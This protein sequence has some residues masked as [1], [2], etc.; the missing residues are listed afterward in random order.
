MGIKKRLYFIWEWSGR[1][2]DWWGRVRII[3]SF[4]MFFGGILLVL[5]VFLVNSFGVVGSALLLIGTLAIVGGAIGIWRE[6]RRAPSSS[7][8]EAGDEIPTQKTPAAVGIQETE[9]EDFEWSNM[10]A[11]DDV[12]PYLADSLRLSL[13]GMGDRWRWGALC[14][15]RTPD[16]SEYQSPKVLP[17]DEGKAEVFYPKDFPTGAPP[18]GDGV[19]TV[20]WRS[21]AEHDPVTITSRPFSARLIVLSAYWEGRKP[22]QKLVLEAAVASELVRGGHGRYLS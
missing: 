3:S 5:W 13:A 11:A 17:N 8:L 1:I 10:Y 21:A 14:S 16:G 12:Q 20:T 2:N 9:S 7:Q 15:V 19:Y 18:V 6:H 22:G 4:L